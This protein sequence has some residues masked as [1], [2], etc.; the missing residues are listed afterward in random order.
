MK[1]KSRLNSAKLEVDQSGKIEQLNTLT[2]VAAAN[3]HKLTVGINTTEMA[4]T[5]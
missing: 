3:G 4:G 5:P 1:T 2:I